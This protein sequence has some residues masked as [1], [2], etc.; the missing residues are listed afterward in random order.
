[1]MREI[2]GGAAVVIAVL[3]T[4]IGAIAEALHQVNPSMGSRQNWPE[5]LMI[6]ALWAIAA[7][8]CSSDRRE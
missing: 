6:G 3:F 2:L 7:A 1:M 5:L 4:G 8:V